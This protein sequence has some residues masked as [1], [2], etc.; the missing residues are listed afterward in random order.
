MSL[1]AIVPVKP[2]RQGKSRLSK[3]LSEA[4]REVLN[5]ELLSKTLKC[6]SDI[7]EIDQILVISYDPSALALSRSFGAKTIQENRRTNI[8]KALRRATLAAKAFKATRVIIIPA[9]IPLIEPNSI[10]NII[11]LSGSPPEIIITPDRKMNGTN[12]LLINPIGAIDYDFGEWSFKKHVEQAEQKHIRIVKYD[13]DKIGF[14]LD[15]PE[16]LELLEKFKEIEKDFSYL[17]KHQEVAP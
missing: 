14:D 10:K 5:Q 11:S 16:D 15:L 2:L 1:W 13:S 3:V 4:Q 6:L 8:N 9:D 17:T 7:K 12:A